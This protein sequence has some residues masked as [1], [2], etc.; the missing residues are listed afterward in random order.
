MIQCRQKLRLRE[1]LLQETICTQHQGQR[2]LRQDGADDYRDF[3][4]GRINLE[5][6]EQVPTVDTWQHHIQNDH[7]WV[8]GL[9]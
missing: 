9:C 1:R 3:L 2:F 4:R 6:T 5:L 8:K 7:L